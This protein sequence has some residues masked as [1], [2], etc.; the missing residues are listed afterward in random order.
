MAI[1]DI[2][3]H[4]KVIICPYQGFFKALLKSKLFIFPGHLSVR[5]SSVIVLEGQFLRDVPRAVVSIVLNNN[6][7]WL[8]L[9]LLPTKKSNF[10][11]VKFANA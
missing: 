6:F 9:Q 5:F 7:R 2:L 4:C 11:F 10:F 8:S 1:K 3:I